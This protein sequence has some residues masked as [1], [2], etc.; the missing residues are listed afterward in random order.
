MECDIADHLGIGTKARATGEEAIARVALEHGGSGE[1]RLPIGRTREEGAE[2][3][4]LTPTVRHE[5]DCEPV[6]Q[7][8][9]S[10]RRRAQAE[11][12]GGLDQ[13]LAEDGLPKPVDGDAGGGGRTGIDQPASEG[14]AIG[15]GGMRRM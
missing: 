10:G 9:M 3:V 8:L 5:L 12:V 7:R 14:E 13:A 4:L 15:G 2:E 11:V 1:G 6:E